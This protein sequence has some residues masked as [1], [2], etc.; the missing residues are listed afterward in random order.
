M[1][2]LL[3]QTAQVFANSAW[4]AARNRWLL[5]RFIHTN[6]EVSTYLEK[7]SLILDFGCGV[8]QNSYILEQ[9]GFQVMGIELSPQTDWQNLEQPFLVYDGQT[10]PFDDNSF[11]AVV[12][13]GVLE[14]VG[15]GVKDSGKEAFWRTQKQRAEVLREIYRVLKPGGYVFIY[16]FPN[17]LSP[18]ELF[19]E[20]FNITPRHQGSEKQTLPEVETLVA[21]CGFEI[22]NSGRQGV[23][24]ASL[25]F[26]SIWFREQIINKFW[27]L[28]H[29][30]DLLVD[31]RLARWLGQSNYVIGR[32]ID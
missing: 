23:L 7:N 4:E 13:Y 1:V 18:I 22:T 27:R 24:P 25:G 5:A 10:L 2:K 29:R 32:K 19:L 21:G 15:S 26:F 14:H 16:N 17:R 3:D 20:F 12:L 8:G 31:G 30:I 6:L 9:L 28:W 11:S